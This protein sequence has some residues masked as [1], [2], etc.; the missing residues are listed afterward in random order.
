[1]VLEGLNP[2]NNDVSSEMGKYDVPALEDGY[3]D[4][5]FWHCGQQYSTCV[6]THRIQ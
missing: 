6:R 1:M 2:F 3:W 5:N 4:Q